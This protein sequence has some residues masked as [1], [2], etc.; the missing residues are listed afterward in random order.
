MGKKSKSAKMPA[1]GTAPAHYDP[2]IS[3]LNAALRAA[4]HAAAPKKRRGSRKNRGGPKP[5]LS[6][7][8]RW[9]DCLLDPVGGPAR[10]PDDDVRKSAVA[11]SSFVWTSTGITDGSGG[12]INLLEINPASPWGFT[13]TAASALAPSQISTGTAAGT[14]AGGIVTWSTTTGVT[15]SHAPNIVSLA[16]G[17]PIWTTAGVPSLPSGAADP[18]FIRGT[19]CVLEV[20]YTGTASGSSGSWFAGNIPMGTGTAA[21]QGLFA[22]DTVTSMETSTDV[23]TLREPMNLRLTWRPFSTPT[24]RSTITPPFPTGNTVDPLDSRMIFCARG[25]TVD[26]TTLHFKI[27]ANWEIVVADEASTV[28]ATEPSPSDP[29]ELAHA[30]NTLARTKMATEWGPNPV[31]NLGGGMPTNSRSGAGRGY[32]TSGRQGPRRRR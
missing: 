30:R 17:A 14:V 2:R 20:A 6:R 8:R 9:V 7:G 19:G 32:T 11:Q 18:N 31:F 1:V 4:G 27:H 28:F 5:G 10:I 21:S 24:Y 26:S 12:F 29:I 15:G 25:P 3:T 23:D 13:R 22:T 16:A